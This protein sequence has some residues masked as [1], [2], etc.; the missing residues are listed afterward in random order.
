MYDMS[1]WNIKF[2]IFL[3][4][5]TKTV[6]FCDILMSE[7]ESDMAGGYDSRINVTST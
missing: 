2:R 5:V 6:L 4:F 1:L 3:I 7:G